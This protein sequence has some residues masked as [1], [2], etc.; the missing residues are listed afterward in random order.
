MMLA[1]S[2]STCHDYDMSVPLPL[3]G[4]LSITHVPYHFAEHRTKHI[5]ILETGSL[6]SIG[7]LIDTISK[8]EK[9]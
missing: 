9:L 4:F 5:K 8:Q 6:T 2:I 1:V 7:T 3:L